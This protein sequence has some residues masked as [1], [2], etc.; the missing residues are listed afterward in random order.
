MKALDPAEVAARLKAARAV[1]SPTASEFARSAGI[2]QSAYSQFE[3][4]AR[5]LITTA[6]LK[7][8]E[9]CHLTLDWLYRGDPSGLP[10]GLATQLIAQLRGSDLL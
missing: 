2:T 8:Y 3:T 5:F 1:L 10:H 9:R 7:L 6:A 4:G